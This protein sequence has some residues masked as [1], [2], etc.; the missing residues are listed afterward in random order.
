MK[1]QLG[2]Q[3]ALLVV[4]AQ[5]DFFPGGALAVDEGDEIIPVLNAWIE[6]AEEA[7]SKIYATR[8]WHPE[9]HSTFK[10]QGGPWPVHCVQGSRGAEFHP[11]LNLPSRTKVVSK[12]DEPDSEGYSAFQ[13]T[14]LSSRL[15]NDDVV[16]L[17]VGGLAQDYCVKHTV[18]DA[19]KT[20]LEVHLIKPATRPVNL[21]P[22]DG[23]EALQQMLAAGAI[24]EE[25]PEGQVVAKHSVVRMA[26]L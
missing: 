11:R 25:S 20:G 9:N 13:A 1:A 15:Q 17:W 5:N 3:D 6:A 14:D 8:D 22:G 12:G 21:N 16:R 19:L 23:D 26:H 18:L 7:G 4:D 24:L 2:Y 10:P